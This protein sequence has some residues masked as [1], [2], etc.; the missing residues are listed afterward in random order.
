MLSSFLLTCTLASSSPSGDIHRFEDVLVVGPVAQGG[1]TPC[2]V[3]PIAYQMVTGDFKAPTQG[4]KLLLPSGTERTW[5]PAKAGAD[6]WVSDG[7]FSG[8]YAFASF[9]SASERVAILEAAGHTMVYVN[10]EPRGG[11]PYGF[12][13]LKLPVLLH[14]GENQFLFAV[15]RGR[16]TAKL[17]EP[18]SAFAILGDDPT[19]PDQIAG[20]EKRLECSVIVSNA[21]KATIRGR[22]RCE[23]DGHSGEWWP[24]TVTPLTVKKIRFQ[25]PMMPANSEGKVTLRVSLSTGAGE[26]VTSTKEF[27]LDVRPRTS[28]H[29]RT[30]VSGIDGSVQY[31]AVQPGTDKGAKAMVLSLHGA[32]VEA[33]G[34]AAA[35]GQKSWCDIVCP[36]NGRPYGFDWEDWGRINALETLAD[37]KRL[38]KPLEDRIY[39]TGHSMGGHGTYSIGVTNPGLFAAIAP[40]A[41]WISFW[42]YAGGADWKDAD[43]VEK[44]LRRAANGSD[45]LKMLDNTTGLGVYIQH[46]DADD[47]VPVE[48]AREMRRRLAEFHKDFDWH[49]EPGQGHWF[50]TDP[51]PGAN[52]E[53]YAPL[54]AF[55]AKHRILLGLEGRSAKFTS[56]NPGASG[57][58]RYLVMGSQVV[59]LDPSTVEAKASPDGKEITASTKNLSSLGF[60]TDS[61]G[62]PES[63]K[64]RLDGSDPIE[65]QN[66]KGVVWFESVEGKWRLR[67]GPPDPAKVKLVSNFKSAFLN[68]VCLVYGTKPG[69]E[70]SR[71]SYVRARYDAETWMYRGN[72]SLELVPDS[73][74]KWSDTQGPAPRNVVLYG[75]PTGNAAFGPGMK[76]MPA[77]GS[78][79]I[80]ADAGILCL[81]R[82]P[83]G[84]GIVGVIGGASL[85]GCRVTER[86]SVF[87]SG[88]HFADFFV[89]SPEMYLKGS[90]GVLATGYFGNEWQYDEKSAAWR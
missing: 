14:K 15:G 60:D 19:F 83:V 9:K 7:A 53:D 23:V 64:V 86:L 21:T 22:L 54:F 68:R 55:L 20:E 30:F 73:E 27:S 38:Y 59:C 35:Y 49:E 41:G 11:D 29:K 4:D 56:V 34:Q 17:T 82:N 65:V 37:A 71:W 80:P 78:H 58:Y 43:P 69:N 36:T 90:K 84:R 75:N 74:F 39:L 2:P 57:T 50:D 62:S 12:G 1:R 79:G 85:T 44:V 87:S 8:G 10:G 3:D 33:S 28:V 31:Y 45:T 24:A 81:T 67:P 25:T 32:S 63:L 46:G 66:P 47:N 40:C 77:G 5:K 6:G 48:Q 51:E 16:M 72:G 26:P 52:C 89:A 42:S 18:E 61:L 76:V 13:Y 88:V 70:I